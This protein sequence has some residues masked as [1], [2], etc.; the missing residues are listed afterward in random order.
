MVTDGQRPFDVFA[1]EV[2]LVVSSF[3]YVT[4]WIF[5]SS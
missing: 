4:S 5:E 3:A 1:D 2:Y